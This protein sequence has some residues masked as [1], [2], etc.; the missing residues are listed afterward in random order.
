MRFTDPVLA[1]RTFGVYLASAGAGFALAPTLILPLLGLPAPTDSWIRV[2]GIL[3]AILGMYFIYCAQP[4]ARRFFEA[5]VIARLMFFTGVATL[6]VL[7]LAPPLLVLFGVVDLVGAG[8][9]VY[10]LRATKT[11]GSAG[12]VV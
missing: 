11:L 2:V 4:G 9:T 6:A 3:T 12:P 1:S 7:G 5:T 10:A 8:W